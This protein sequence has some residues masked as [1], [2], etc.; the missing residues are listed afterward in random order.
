MIQP[1]RYRIYEQR[2]GY[3][4]PCPYVLLCM[5]LSYSLDQILLPLFIYVLGSFILIRDY[6]RQGL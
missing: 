6:L 5:D 3:S 4:R 2:V 1:K